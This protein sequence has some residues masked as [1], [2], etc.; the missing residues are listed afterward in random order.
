MLRSAVLSRTITLKAYDSPSA[1][2]IPIFFKPTW[3][4]APG[5]VC[6]V[7]CKH[8]LRVVRE[9]GAGADGLCG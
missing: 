8:L 1:T 2:E 5:A 9:L 4:T 6:N 7:R 3:R